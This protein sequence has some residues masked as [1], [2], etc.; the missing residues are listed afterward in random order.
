VSTGSGAHGRAAQAAGGADQRAH[1][2]S[3]AGVRS[4]PASE[5]GGSGR[6]RVSTSST[7]TGERHGQQAGP[8]SE[9]TRRLLRACVLL[10]RASVAARVRTG[11]CMCSR[12]GRRASSRGCNHCHG[13]ELFLPIGVLLVS[14]SLHS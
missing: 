6:A 5:R 14:W 11:S 3:P 12:R 8:M 9:L 7:R 4:A 13:R 1:A 10:R 2:A